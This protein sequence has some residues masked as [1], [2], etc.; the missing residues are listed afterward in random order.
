MG[1]QSVPSSSSLP[2]LFATI[3][4]LVVAVLTVLWL[5]FFRTAY[6]PVFQ[7]I[8]ETDASAI[9]AQLD[10]AGIPYASE[11]VAVR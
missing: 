9:V 3:F 4:V 5:V 10:S 2:R 11:T 1:L 6:A 7:N 8:R